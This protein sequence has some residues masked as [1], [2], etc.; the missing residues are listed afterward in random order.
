MNIK[1]LWA[2]LPIAGMAL[3]SCHK[4]KDDIPAVN[5]AQGKITNIDGKSIHFVS[6][7]A[8]GAYHP[9]DEDLFLDLTDSK[10]NIDMI[11]DIYGIA[12][13]EKGSYPMDGDSTNDLTVYIGSNPSGSWYF[14]TCTDLDGDADPD[15]SGTVSISTLT[16]TQV[17]GVIKK[18]TCVNSNP[19]LPPVTLSD[20]KFNIEIN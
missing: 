5:T 6:S 17:I 7:S 4:H 12:L 15:G 13:G 1:I 3:M 16:S 2:I 10:N 11:I 9:S 18:A 19:S 8:S 20:C 14:C